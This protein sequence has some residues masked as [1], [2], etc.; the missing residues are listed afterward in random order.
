MGTKN[1]PGKFDY[2][3]RDEP[4]EPRF[5]LL[6]RDRE[7]ALLV[8]LWAT[9]RGAAGEASEVV[10]WAHRCA[11]AMREYAVSR[12]KK[13]TSETHLMAVLGRDDGIGDD[14]DDIAQFHEKFE[15]PGRATPGWLDADAE[16]FRIKFLKEELGE[17]LEAIEA[18]DLP[19]AAD[20]LV[21]LAY[22]TLGTA[23]LMGI[24]WHRVWGA[25]HQANMRKVI[26]L[27]AAESTRGYSKDVI[28]P[29]G[30]QPPDIAAVLR[31]AG[32]GGPN[33][34]GV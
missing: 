28:K 31:Q 13:P 11:A 16:A 6:G 2:Y 30:W 34:V 21:D 17:F 26:A 15:L 5:T 4:D 19:K 12:G 14:F 27:S 23:Y 7:A 33:V 29:P 9:L 3:E 24:P 22:V 8:S 18:R 32:W 1:H 20:S 10:F 25:V